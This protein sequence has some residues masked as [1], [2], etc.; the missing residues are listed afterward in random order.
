MKKVT[1]SIIALTLS[2]VSATAFACPKG[3]TLQGRQGPHHKGGKCV[4]AQGNS[5]KKSNV[6]KKTDTTAK[7]KIEKQKV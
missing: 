4:T 1:S 6:E 3:T 5:I 2:V 7:S